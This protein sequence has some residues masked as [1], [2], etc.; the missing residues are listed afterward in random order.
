MRKHRKNLACCHPPHQD[1]AIENVTIILK[2]IGVKN[3]NLINPS[4]IHWDI[5]LPN[6]DRFVNWGCYKLNIFFF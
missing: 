4:T 1:G 2:F 3:A 5:G 6:Y